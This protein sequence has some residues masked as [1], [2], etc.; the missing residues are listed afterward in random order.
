MDSKA[1][2][3]SNTANLARSAALRFVLLIGVVSFFADMT[4]EGA[5]GVTGP[6]LASLGA[7]ATVVGIVAGLGELLGYGLRLVFG[8]FTDRTGK[9]WPIAIVGYAINLV[10]VPLLALAG[11]WPVAAL[12]MIAER[13]GRAMRTPARDAMISHAS[14]ELGSGWVFG[15]REALDASGAMLGPLIVAAVLAIRGSFQDAFAILTIPVLLTFV[16]LIISI[17]LYPRP[18]DL[19]KR[20]PLHVAEGFPRVFWVYLVGMGLIAAAFADYPLIAYHFSVAHVFT[21]D[22]IPILYAVAMGTEA[23][24][25]LVMGRLFDRVGLWTVVGAT[26]LTACFAPLVF[27]GSAPLAVL[28]MICWGLGA[29]AQESIVKA[30][31]TGM[32]HPR[33]RATAYGLF[34]TG[35]GVCWFLGSVILGILYDHTVVGLVVFSVVLQLAAIPVLL[36]TRQRLAQLHEAQV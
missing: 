34:D 8:Y 18:H 16:A 26:V 30:A 17:R 25:A 22:V 12:L 10:A 28:G 29:A 3:A 15:V 23:I 5:R 11:N 36:W 27:L 31:I 9:Y 7:S 32:V 6:F 14:G 1:T 20:P 4:H 2:K 35:F 21:T 33:Q 19:E 13:S 24:A